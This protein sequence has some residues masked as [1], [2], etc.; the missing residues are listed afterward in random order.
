M[1]TAIIVLL[2]GNSKSG[3]EWRR[4]VSENASRML[5]LGRYIASTTDA[6]SF[7]AADGCRRRRSEDKR[8]TF[9]PDKERL[10]TLEE[11]S[12]FAITGASSG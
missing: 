12:V 7:P 1:E 8:S 3:K 9:L 11:L 4:L 10:R 6:S 5:F 2:L